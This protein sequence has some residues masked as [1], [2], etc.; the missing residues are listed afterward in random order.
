[1][2]PEGGID[3]GAGIHGGARSSIDRGP[4]GNV[5]MTESRGAIDRRSGSSARRLMEGCSAGRRCMKCR[6]LGSTAATRRGPKRRAGRGSMWCCTASTAAARMTSTPPAAATGIPAAAA[7][8]RMT[9]ATASATAWT[10]DRRAGG[11]AA[12]E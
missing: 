3:A 11:E 6:L 8:A 12:L 10:S 7:T 5:R 9:S 2:S 4:R 1:M